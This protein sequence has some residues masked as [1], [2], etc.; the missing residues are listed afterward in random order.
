MTGG[1]DEDTILEM[2]DVEVTYEMGR[3]RARVLDGID[4]DIRRGETIALVGESGSGKTMLASTMMDAVVDPGVTSGE[5]LYHPEEGD[6]I[7]LLE[8]NQRQ[9]KRLRWEEIAMV[10]QGAMN[11]FN[12]T[13]D[14]KAHFTETFDA[15]DI[16]R[17]SGLKR[18]RD[19]L[20]QL[21][22]DSDRIL[23][24]YQHELSGGEKQRA[25]LA[26]S[27]VFDPEVLI[28]DEP[29]AALDILM[30]RNIL[31]I[32][33]DL[34]EMYDLT[35]V[36]ITHDMPIVSGF[37]DRIAVMYAFQVVELGRARDVLLNPEHPYTRLMLRSTLDLSMPVEAT[38]TIEG[39]TPDP[40]NV[41]TGCRFHPRCPAADDRCEVE[42]PELRGDSEHEAAC[43]YPDVGRNRIPVTL[44]EDEP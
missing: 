23:D 9:L 35:L 33:Y 15:H 40:I 38:R 39:Q 44:E 16:D 19:L 3:G 1:T 7:N 22:L 41:P 14:I 25:L 4:L 42:D 37:A 2:R 43:F 30:Q 21:N 6:P 24:S 32:L 34:Q 36:F 27:L 10:Y 29:T 12:P 31:S 5:V 13:Q 8:L 11:A 20:Q 26:L 28:L 18:A 17:Q